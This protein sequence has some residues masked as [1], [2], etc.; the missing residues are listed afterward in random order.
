MH[1]ISQG[2]TSL[3]I[4]IKRAEESYN[5]KF[6]GDFCLK[7][8][9]GW[10]SDSCGA[11][12]YVENPDR[13]LGHTNYFALVLQYGMDLKRPQLFITKGDSAFEQPIVGVVADDGEVVYSRYRHDMRWSTD[14][15]VAIDGGNDYTIVTGNIDCKQVH[16]TADG[17]ELR[18][19]P[20][21][22]ENDVRGTAENDLDK[23]APKQGE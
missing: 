7:T 17:D 10:A 19:I 5:A 20:I 2:K 18:I 12:F 16:I 8:K 11:V 15:S 4:D 9:Y 13:S 23:I 1:I 14:G 3:P 22:V 21:D 6:M